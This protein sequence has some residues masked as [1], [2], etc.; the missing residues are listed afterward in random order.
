[1]LLLGRMGRVQFEFTAS[2]RPVSICERHMTPLQVPVRDHPIDRSVLDNETVPCDLN[3]NGQTARHSFARG[4]T[5]GSLFNGRCSLSPWHPI[6]FLSLGRTYWGERI[7]STREVESLEHSLGHVASNIQ[8][9][10]SMTIVYDS[11]QKVW[12]SRLVME[13]HTM[14]TSSKNPCQVSRRPTSLL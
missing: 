12:S 4:Q 13:N 8:E 11:P 10:V 9:I 1:M 2:S 5:L 14:S 6:T 7:G 3:C